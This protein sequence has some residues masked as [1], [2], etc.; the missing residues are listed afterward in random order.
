M[1]SLETPGEKA[2]TPIW[3]QDTPKRT[4]K[5]GKRDGCR[6]PSFD[7]RNTWKWPDLEIWVLVVARLTS[8]K[9]A[10]RARH[11]PLK[12]EPA[13]S[14][15]R[16]ASIRARSDNLGAGEP[17][18]SPNASSA[19]ALRKSCSGRPGL[20][21][22]AGPRPIQGDS[23]KSI[24]FRLEHAARGDAQLTFGPFRACSGLSERSDGFPG[25]VDGGSELRVG[26]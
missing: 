3:G 19:C 1:D 7:R 13:G 16:R 8:R 9:S 17:S 10:V 11:R 22:I 20:A 14:G 5:S 25:E 12:E 26:S 23:C 6:I 4:A 18:L 15:D 24:A 2:P 21:R